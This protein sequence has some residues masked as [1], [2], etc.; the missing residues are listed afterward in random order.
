MRIIAL[1]FGF[2]SIGHAGRYLVELKAPSPAE[3]VI[4]S[5]ARNPREA[6]LRMRTGVR[7][8]LERSRA[9]MGLRE[10]EIVY[11]MDFLING[12]AVDI[13][14]ERKRELA[15]KPEVRAVH[16][17]NAPMRYILD[18]AIG[19]LRVREAMAL[20]S[21]EKSGGAGVKIG[22]IDSSLDIAHPAFQDPE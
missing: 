12:F 18:E 9:A 21:P 8:A 15:A 22:I 7:A 19:L 1:F 17:L 11:R 5:R 14:E 4:A 20:V 16:D 2:L 6:A 10:A 3:S 13:S